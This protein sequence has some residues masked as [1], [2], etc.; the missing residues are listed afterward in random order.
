MDN[1][2]D[3]FASKNDAMQWMTRILGEY[4]KPV[5]IAK[6]QNLWVQPPKGLLRYPSDWDYRLEKFR[7]V[8]SSDVQSENKLLLMRTDDRGRSDQALKPVNCIMP[9]PVWLRPCRARR[10]GNWSPYIGG[11]QVYRI[12]PVEPFK[13][14]A[15]GD[16]CLRAVTKKYDKEKAGQY[17]LYRLHFKQK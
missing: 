3:T 9:F 16:L 13:G 7:G 15:S 12:G 14:K 17:L 8:F 5:T 4:Y 10:S 1:K 2:T 11:G 6:W